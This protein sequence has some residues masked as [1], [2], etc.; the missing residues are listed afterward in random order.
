MAKRLQVILQDTEYR[1]VQRAARAQN[2]T[3]AAWVRQALST[4]RRREPVGDVAR[5]FDVVRDAV[6]HAFPTAEID[7]MNEEIE[8]GYRTVDGP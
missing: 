8:R 3:V 6:R 2:L 4:A 1:D 7:E 5:K